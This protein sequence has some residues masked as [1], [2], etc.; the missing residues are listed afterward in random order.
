MAMNL[1]NMEINMHH[2][3]QSLNRIQPFSFSQKCKYGLAK[4]ISSSISPVIG[5]F[6]SVIKMKIKFVPVLI[7]FSFEEI[8]KNSWFVSLSSLSISIVKNINLH[9]ILQQ[10]LWEKE[11]MYLHKIN[12]FFNCLLMLHKSWIPL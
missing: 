10:T 4:H 6:I 12:C 5:W 2:Y 8:I 11:Y 7:C 9:I 3:I 1:K